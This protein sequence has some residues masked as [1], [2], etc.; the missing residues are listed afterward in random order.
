MFKW[1]KKLK[2]KKE[3]KP[4]EV[5]LKKKGTVQKTELPFK[6][7]LSLLNDINNKSFQK[8]VD[9]FS[10]SPNFAMDSI[11]TFAENDA[12]VSGI[13]TTPANLL[14]LNWYA[15]Q[16]FIGYQACAILA[17]HWLINK[18]CELPARDSVRN[19]F[20]ITVNDGSDISPEILDEM[21]S[22][23]ADF[24]IDENLIQFVK[25]GK[26]FG[27]RVAK[28][29]VESDDPRYYE[30]PFNPDGIKPGSYKG[31]E[32]IDPYWCMPQL[33]EKATS[34]PGSLGFYEPTW[35]KVGND[36]IHRSHLVIYKGSEVAD[37]LKPSYRW[38]GMSIP[39]KIYE[40]VY[41]A[42][43][44]ANE[45]PMLAITKRSNI[46]QTDLSAVALDECSV[47]H[48]I[49]RWVHFHNNYG[50]KLADINDKISQ[51][52]TS[53]SDFESLI[54]TQYEL[55]A[56][57]ADYSYVKLFGAS[58]KGFNSSGNSE[59]EN[60]REALESIQKN[61]MN[62]LLSRHYLCVIRSVICPKYNIDPF[63]I[64]ITWNSLN[65][66]TEKEKSEVNKIKA[67][68]GS[69]LQRSGAIN[70]EDERN[71][72]ITDEDS[73]YNG[74]ELDTSYD[75]VDQLIQDMNEGE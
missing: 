19:G 50:V 55:V 36:L 26:V 15:S 34:S 30:K 52:D 3:I 47:E 67:E 70:A 71:R 18:A 25:M 37:I 51:I 7:N 20:E 73:G 21:R 24:K 27:I 8:S 75:E 62:P 42:E 13:S 12:K 28:F 48:R 64:C 14:T 66:M 49:N 54:R 2:S 1:L 58:P 33:D 44:T 23:D 45:A 65:V 10:Y 60:V 53:L 22:L 57:I 4:A 31:I 46:Y 38:G 68:T 35:W 11:G 5:D 74:I 39:Q 61:D 16:G 9:E 69:I 43:R 59:M 6:S 63:D 32:Q 41:A 29:V 56:S 72:I 40:R 17:Q